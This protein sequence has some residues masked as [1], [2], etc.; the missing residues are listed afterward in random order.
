MR[1]MNIIFDDRLSFSAPRLFVN[2]VR[3]AA[4]ARGITIADFGREALAREARR[5]GVP[6]PQLPRLSSLNPRS[7]R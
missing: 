5:V 1:S 2:A 6:C 4:E 7:S 3:R